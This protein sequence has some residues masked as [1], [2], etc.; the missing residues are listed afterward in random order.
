MYLLDTNIFLEILLDQEKKLVCQDFISIHSEHVYISDFSLHSIAIILIRYK[1][2]DVLKEF[3]ADIISKV[4]ILTLPASQYE[5]LIDK[6][7]HLDLDFDDIYQYSVAKQ[8]DLTIVTMDTDFKKV[9][10]VNVIFL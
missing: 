5:S 2:Y 6:V 1:K 10:D 8:F 4:D 7:P 3:Y 9:S